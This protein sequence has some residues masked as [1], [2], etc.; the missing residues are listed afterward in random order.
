MSAE[1]GIKMDMTR[2]EFL[3]NP[4][5]FIRKDVEQAGQWLRRM[6]AGPATACGGGAASAGEDVTA[7]PRGVGLREARE[8][9][10]RNTHEQQ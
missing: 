2:R 6:K 5:R 3:T 4:F 10:G 7:A 9:I 1:K 8:T